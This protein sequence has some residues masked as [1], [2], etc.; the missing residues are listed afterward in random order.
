MKKKL[1]RIG[2]I[3]ILITVAGI[4]LFKNSKAIGKS[5]NERLKVQ[6]EIE[7]GKKIQQLGLLCIH[8][9]DMVKTRKPVTYTIDTTL[10]G[11]N[12]TGNIFFTIPLPHMVFD[13]STARY[14]ER[15][16]YV[17]FDHCMRKVIETDNDFFKNICIAYKDSFNTQKPYCSEIKKLLALMQ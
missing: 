5:F 11:D 6:E 8:I 9:A 12:P 14:V 1:L 13:D 16:N 10:R 3:A 15:M 7:R 4:Y 17:V 2:I